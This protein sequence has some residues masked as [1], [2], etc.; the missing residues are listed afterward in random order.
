MIT[1]EQIQSNWD[2]FL[3][4]IDTHITGERKDKLLEFYKQYEDRFVL[5]PASHKKAYHNCFPGGYID[6]VI[7]VIEAAIKVDKVSKV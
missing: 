4:I 6:H 7:R 1:A 5:L 2:K 3:N